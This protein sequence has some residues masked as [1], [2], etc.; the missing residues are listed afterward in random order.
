MKVDLKKFNHIVIQD[1]DGEVVDSFFIGMAQTTEGLA[2]NI[3]TLRKK[4]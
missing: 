4:V 3:L 2:G 1:K